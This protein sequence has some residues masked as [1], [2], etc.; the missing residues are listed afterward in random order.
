MRTNQQLI[1]S[2]ERRINEVSVNLLKKAAK[3]VVD[4]RGAVKSTGDLFKDV[5]AANRWNKAKNLAK[6]PN[7]KHSANSLKKAA[8]KVYDD[9]AMKALKNMKDN[10]LRDRFKTASALTLKPNGLG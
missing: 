10:K 3:N 7:S 5:S 4:Q 2:L 8:K 9:R 6:L 1:E